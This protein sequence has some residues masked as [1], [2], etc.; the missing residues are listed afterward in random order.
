MHR[1]SIITT[2]K[3][4]LNDLRQSLPQFLKQDGAEVIVVDYDCPD[5]TGE[6][7]RSNFPSTKVVSLKNKPLFNISHAKNIGAQQASADVLIFLDADIVVSD[8]FLLSLNFPYDKGCYGTFRSHFGDSLR[9]SCVV[10]REHFEEV[11]GYDEL[12]SGYEGEDLD[13]YMR[14]RT[15]GVTFIIL[16]DDRIKNVIEQSECERL[17]FRPQSDIKKQFLRGQLYQLAK[18]MVLNTLRINKLELDLRKNILHQVDLQIDSL[19]NGQETFKLTINFPDRY[20][21]GLLKDW[22]FSTAVTV[23]ARRKSLL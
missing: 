10:R 7:V 1:Y 14:L 22:E 15:A 5:G 23:N 17:R 9:G 16:N 11:D 20:K 2:C 13:L 6:F 4:R 21:R 12:L 18:E 8:D 19:F 3:G